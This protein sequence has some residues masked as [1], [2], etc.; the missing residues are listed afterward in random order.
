MIDYA[1]IAK[2]VSYYKNHGYEYIEV[3]WFVS[4]ETI[5]VTRPPGARYFDT[6]AGHLVASGEQ[7]FIEIRKTLKEGHRYQCVT[8]CFRDEAH[9]DLHRLYFLKQE[10]ILVGEFGNK[11]LA[12]MIDT[13]MGFFDLYGDPKVVQ[14]DIGFDIFINDIEVGS[15]GLRRHEDFHW[16]YGTGCAEPRL[17]QSLH[18]SSSS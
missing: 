11:E 10:L 9:D 15:Y 1:K 2:A 7:S 3:P 4:Q 18:H 16:V 6:F 17:T 12:D 8:P 14:T 5:D 13:A